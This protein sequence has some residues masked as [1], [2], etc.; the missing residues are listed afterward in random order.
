MERNNSIVALE[1]CT[2]SMSILKNDWKSTKERFFTMK[3][4]IQMLRLSIWIQKWR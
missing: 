4:M 1:L 3:T 2:N